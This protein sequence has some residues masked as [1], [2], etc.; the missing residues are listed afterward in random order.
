MNVSLPEELHRS[1]EARARSRHFASVSEYVRH[2]IREDLLQ[3]RQ[4]EAEEAL[5]TSLAGEAV[6]RKTIL[7]AMEAMTK[8][9]DSVNA[10][11]KGPP[12][13]RG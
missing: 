2:L 4:E 10:R 12:C 6:D 9:R 1:A 8:L 11:G 3:A 5:V 7:K 13:Q